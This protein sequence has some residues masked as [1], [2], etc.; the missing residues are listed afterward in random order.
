MCKPRFLF[1]FLYTRHGR[2]HVSIP[3][4]RPDVWLSIF[5]RLIHGLTTFDLFTSVR[6]PSSLVYVLDVDLY[7]VP[8]WSF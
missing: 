1:S 2:P 5:P 3:P 8:H 6:F 4:L 7:P